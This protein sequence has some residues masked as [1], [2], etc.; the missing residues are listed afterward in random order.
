M[1]LSKKENIMRRRFIK[2]IIT[3]KGQ[4]MYY[5]GD[6]LWFGRISKIN[7]RNSLLRN[8]K[9][10]PE[11]THQGSNPWRAV[12]YFRGGNMKKI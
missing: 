1:G 2:K 7:G 8:Q 3:K 11:K 10:R 6:G 12:S 5:L 9:A 4:V